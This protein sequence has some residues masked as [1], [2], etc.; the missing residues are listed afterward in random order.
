M[1]DYVSSEDS[2]GSLITITFDICRVTDTILP[3]IENVSYTI[4]D[5]ATIIV[6]EEFQS[7]EADI[8]SYQWTY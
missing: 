4:G 7:Q 5:T 1:A 6:F 2:D 3:S 8:C